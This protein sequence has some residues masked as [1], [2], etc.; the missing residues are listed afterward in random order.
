VSGIILVTGASGRLGGR[1]VQCLLE[2]VPANRVAAL[3][4][5]VAQLPDLSGRGV[6]VRVGDYYDTASMT[7]AFAEVE[8]L[9]MV[10]APS[11]TDAITAHHNVI[12]AAQQAGVAHVHFA[13]IQRRADSRF[14]IAQVT[15][16]NRIAEHELASADLD[17]TIL[18]NTL[19]VDALDDLIGEPDARGEIRVPAGQ[20]RAAVPTRADI[21]EA[22]A[23]V[24]ATDGHAG[25]VYDLA[26]S[27]PI[28]L[29]EV[30]AVISTTYGRPVTYQDVSV[31]QFVADRS[32]RGL[33]EEVVRF[34]GDWFSAIAADEFA[35]TGML[36]DLLGRS[37]TDPL[38]FISRRRGS[39]SSTARRP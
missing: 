8:K 2:R 15:E 11:F 17:V 18:R 22:S 24:L 6:Q 26:G 12:T 13:S 36:G 10:S 29:E 25:C 3:C 37:P 9:M 23:A 27:R 21:A 34:Q 1:I 38:S 32:D 28:T 19:Y 33:P 14:A 7:D 5:N 16:W 39:V 35:A 4:R 20:G 31:E 30:A